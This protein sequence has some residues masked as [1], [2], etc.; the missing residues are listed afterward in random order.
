[1]GVRY[2]LKCDRC[3]DTDYTERVRTPGESNLG[4]FKNVLKLE[5]EFLYTHCSWTNESGAS[6]DFYLLCE[7]CQSEYEELLQKL[8]YEVNSSIHKFFK[9]AERVLE[10]HING[11][12]FELE[13]END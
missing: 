4:S 6:D 12:F 3:G 9:P 7:D 8:G 1:M 2:I 5:V 13:E 11:E 10:E